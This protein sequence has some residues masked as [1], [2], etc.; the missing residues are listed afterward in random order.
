MFT[1]ILRCTTDQV[2]VC[3]C[4]Q[5]V[6]GYIMLFNVHVHGEYSALSVHIYETAD[7]YIMNLCFFV[8]K[9]VL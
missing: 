5:H 9:K 2:Q 8:G 3:E 7:S 4:A 6:I 1:K